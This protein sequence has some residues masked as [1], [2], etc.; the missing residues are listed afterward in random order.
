MKTE[1]DLQAMRKKWRKEMV[2]DARR[3][4]TMDEQRLEKLEKGEQDDT[5][6]DRN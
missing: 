2:S 3:E 1:Q 6:K 5:K 4:D